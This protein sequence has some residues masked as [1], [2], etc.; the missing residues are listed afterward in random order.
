M[1]QQ[2]A[3]TAPDVV[4]G[5]ISIL[6][7]DSYTLVDPGATHSFASKPFLDRFQIE[8]QPLE[9][10]MRVSLPAGDP[11]LAER[12]VRDSRVLIEGQEFPADLVALDM[13]D[14][15]VVLGMDWLSRHRATLDCYKKEVKLNRPGKLEVRFR[16]LCRELSSCMISAMAAQRMLRKGCQGYLAYVVET[17]KEGTILDEIPVV[18]EFPDVFPDDIAGLPPEIEVEFAIDLIPGTEPISIP[19]YRMAPAELRE[20]KAQ[21]EE[22]LS[23]G[24]IRPSISPWGAPVLFVKKKYGSLW[25]CIDYRQLNRVTIRNQYPLPRIDELFDQLQGSRVYSKIDLS[26]RYHQLKVQESDVPK[27]AF[28]TRYGHY[29]F[30]VMPFGLTNAPAAFMDLM[31]RVFQPYLDRFVIVFI[32]DILVYLGSSEEHSEHL[33]IVLQTLRERQLYA[34]LSKC[35]FW[36]DKVAFLGHVISAEGVSVDPHKI[37][38]V[39]NWKQPKNVSEVR[40]FLGLA[41]YYRKFVEGF[42]RIAAPLTKL[43]RKDVKYDW[44]DAC[45]R[46]FEELKNRLTSALVLALPNGRDGFVVYSD[47]S[48]QG[49]GCVLMQNDRVIA[50]ASRQLKKHEENYLTH[51]LELAAV[52]FALKIWIH[53]LYGV[54]CRIFTDHKSFQYIFTEKELNLR[55][56]RWLELI[57]DYDCTIEYHPGKANVVADALSRRPESSSSHMRS[58][59]LQLF[60]DLRALGVI[61]EVEDSGALLATFHVRPL[62]VDQILAGQSLD[63]QMIKGKEEIEKGKKTEFQIRDDGMIVKGQRMCVP[64]YGDL[65]REVMEE[66]HSSAYPMHPG[67]TKMYRTLKE[68]YW[69]NGIKKEIAGFVSRCLTCQKVKAKHQRPAGKIQLLPIPVW[70]WE[71]ITMDFVTGLPRTQRQNDAIWVIVDRLTKSAHFLPVNVEDS[72]EK[73]AKLYV[74]E[75]VRLHGVPVSIVSDRDPRF[76]SRFWLSLQAALGTRLH[77]S[78]TFHPQTDGQSERTIQTL[79]DMLRAC[80][81]E[82]KGSWD[83]HLALLEFAYNNS[84]QASIDMAPFEALYGRKCRTPVCWDEFDERRLVGPELVQITS[85]KVKVVRD[86]L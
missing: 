32:D 70:K 49:L 23:K 35:Q 58:G 29:E 57:K 48:R 19:P 79:E 10:R 56:S 86:N 17:G 8:T 5:I 42:S 65:K 64:E 62:L 38:A 36:L 21:L 71:K 11:L 37:K 84:Y 73:F 75:I 7:H 27:T 61:L 68:H 82:F 83:T 40:S 34:K 67:S 44:V 59:Y 52:V 45:H 41:G 46:S 12:V 77:F 26:S 60:V 3:D 63:P 30:L 20:L 33:R 14:F 22:L 66:A 6:D 81:M 4:T 25:L 76:T 53:Y 85:E 39:V 50:Y 54:P 74:H 47:A 69:W 18:R 43:T 16:G 24:F 15:H 72:L 55:Q 51:D 78:T 31:N 28:R 2:D 13:R 80:V 1:A 9:G